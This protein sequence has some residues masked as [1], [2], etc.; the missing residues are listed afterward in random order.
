MTEVSVEAA[1]STASTVQNKVNSRQ[2]LKK[3][4]L[5][6]YNQI[7]INYGKFTILKKFIYKYLLY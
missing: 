7:I 6:D 5:E 3:E 4:N 2:K 1:T